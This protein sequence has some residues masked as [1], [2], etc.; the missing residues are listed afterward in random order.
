MIPVQIVC[1]SKND[2]LTQT[3]MKRK[4]KNKVNLGQAWAQGD[5]GPWINDSDQSNCVPLTEV[6]TEETHTHTHTHTPS[7]ETSGRLYTNCFIS[8][9]GIYWKAYYVFGP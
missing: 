5:K 4:D 8:H 3:S 6:P 2:S 7:Q 1:R 9:R